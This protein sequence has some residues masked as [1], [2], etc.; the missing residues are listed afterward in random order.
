MLLILPLVQG[1]ELHWPAWTVVSLVASVPVFAIFARRQSRLARTGRSPLVEPSLAGKRSYVAGAGFATIFF[2]AMGAMFTIGMMLQIGLGY[3]AIGASLMMA[4]W[5]FGAL[6]GSAVSGVLMAKL[7]RTLLH[8]GLALMG[9]GVLGLVVVYQVAGVEL[10]F[11]AMAASAAGRWHRHGD[12]LRAAVRHRARRGGGPRG[13]FRDGRAQR[14]R[15]AGRHAG[16]RDPRHGVLQ[17]RR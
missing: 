10:G 14:D 5:A 1:H 12:D 11:A 4:P 7:G 17:H 15:A 9:A 8:V 6:V 3:S 2:A 13:R 16:H